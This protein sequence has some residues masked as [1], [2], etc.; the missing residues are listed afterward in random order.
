M[1]SCARI[2]V[3]NRKKTNII[4]GRTISVKRELQIVNYA[5]NLLGASNSVVLP[6]QTK[7]NIFPIVFVKRE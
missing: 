6:Y 5:V 7:S 2:D 4:M 3:G 1:N